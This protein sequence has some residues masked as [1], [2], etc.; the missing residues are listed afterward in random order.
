MIRK[1]EIGTTTNKNGTIATIKNKAI[2]A[3]RGVTGSPQ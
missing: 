3:L 2:L 1:A